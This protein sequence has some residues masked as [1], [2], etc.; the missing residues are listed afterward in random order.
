MHDEPM[1]RNS[2]VTDDDNSWIG[3]FYNM[4]FMD[5]ARERLEKNIRAGTTVLAVDADGNAAG[6]TYTS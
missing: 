1:N 6:N 3:Q 4:G 5:Y 2:F